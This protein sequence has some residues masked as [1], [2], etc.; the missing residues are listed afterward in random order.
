M[1]LHI[2]YASNF[3]EPPR[4]GKVIAVLRT[5]QKQR[6]AEVEGDGLSFTVMTTQDRLTD[7]QTC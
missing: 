1:S 2:S 3:P 4:E 5:S 7:A 6:K